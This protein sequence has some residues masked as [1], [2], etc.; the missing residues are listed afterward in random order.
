MDTGASLE[1]IFGALQERA[2]ELRCLYQVEEIL[3]RGGQ[4]DDVMRDILAVL[5]AGWQFPEICVP[6]LRLGRQIVAPPGFEP[7]EWV[8]AETIR[9]R[10]DAVGELRIYYTEERPPSASGPF[11]EEERQL[12]RAVAERIGEH[13]ATATPSGVIEPG[14]RARWRTVIDF[15]ERTDPRLSAW[16]ARK[17]LNHLRWRGIL[18]DNDIDYPEDESELQGESNRPL[19][20]LPDPG[21]PVAAVFDLAQAYCTEEDIL[22]SL[23]SWVSQDRISFLTHVVERQSSS[24]GEIIQA[25]D[26]FSGLG[27]PESDL[28]RSLQTM[29]RVALLRRFFSNEIEF[30]NTTRDLATLGDFHTL[31][32]RLLMCVDSHGALGGKSAGLFL[33]QRVVENATEHA[34]LLGEIRVPRT[35]YIVSDAAYGFIRYNGLEEV[36]G[37]K[38]LDIE[39]IRQ[40]YP[41]IV[42]AFKNARF[43]TE[44]RNG[45]AAAL[46]DLGDRPL[47]V[48][49]SSLLEDRTGAAFSGKYRSLFLANRGPRE[50]RLHA[51]QDAVAEVYA[52]IFSPDAIEYR[53]ERNLL[54]VHEEMGIMI[55]EVVGR[56][57]GKYF[58]PA[59]SG[60]AFSNNEFRWSPRIRREDGL[61]RLVPGLGTRAVDRTSDDYPVLL[62]PGQPG[63]RAN[64]TVEEVV[65]YAPKQMDVI[66]LDANAFVTVPV[67]TVLRQCGND[68]PMLRDVVSIL[69]D[70][71]MRRPTGLGVDA[72]HDDLIV[73]F[74]GLADN[75][76]FMARM[77][78]L[79]EVLRSRFGR[80]VDIEFACDGDH[81]YLLQ[82]RSQSRADDARPSAIPR[83]LPPERV[84]F[85]AHRFVSNGRVPAITHVVYVDPERYAELADAE[86]MKDVGR[87]VSRINKLLPR[88]KFILMGPG[89]WGSRGDI[90]LGVSVTYS[91]I[92]N[93]AVLVEIAR[94]TGQ[95]V[96]DLSFGTHFFQDLV[97]GDI[98]YLPLY[99]DEP[100]WVLNDAFFRAAHNLLPDL[101][102]EYAH[103]DDVV[104]VIDVPEAT[105]GDI[106]RVLLNG[107]TDEAI[108]FLEPT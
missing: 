80:P 47:I 28:P 104:R 16:L 36:Y 10:F 65:R 98:R 86:D 76:A 1:G 41:H 38:Y 99:P 21:V 87:A 37:Q 27:V 7:T 59:Y 55:Q 33:A 84:L 108:A 3:E 53:A 68:Y 92:N 17:M 51:L 91:G 67:D 24:L 101:V 5:P 31:S 44:L 82:C 71:R 14:G 64:A 60:V 100:G 79:L 18:D 57:V 54:D 9:V 6:W 26:R 29:L 94:R 102:P 40:Q 19:P 8:L 69:E 11:L 93:T 88:R 107:D 46:D 106:V 42:R 25:L 105:G 58:M 61:V 90:R 77:D 52:S 56:R 2:K 50:E 63:L 45:I 83:G 23:K 20:P 48:R 43:P 39:E 62:S 34:D 97:E 15:L 22:D 72:E 35:W 78:A 74:Q 32:Q 85:T 96:P 75:T 4:D 103:L 12:L 89:R 70:G 49:S 13:L 73:T 81:L 66:D 95:Y 30:I